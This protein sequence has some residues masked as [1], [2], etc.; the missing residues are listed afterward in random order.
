MSVDNGKWWVNP[1]GF[2]YGFYLFAGFVLV[3]VMSVLVLT[4][5]QLQVKIQDIKVH[6]Q[7][8]SI[9][10]L[11][12]TSAS[13][14][15]FKQ[16]NA[17]DEDSIAEA[18][19]LFEGKKVERTELLNTI[20]QSLTDYIGIDYDKGLRKKHSA[21]YLQPVIRAE[22]LHETYKEKQDPDSSVVAKIE[23]LLK[24]IRAVQG[25]YN[26]AR[27][28]RNYLILKRNGGYGFVANYTAVSNIIKKHYNLSS[29]PVEIV[30]AVLNVSS[31]I[32]EAEKNRYIP[33]FYSLMTLHSDLLILLLVLMMGALG[34]LIHLAQG[35]LYERDWKRFSYYIFRPL[36]GMSAAFA[37]YILVK[38][39]VLV[40]GNPASAGVTN[41]TSL[42][43]FFISF[44]AI[45]SGL[46]AQ[47][48]LKNI[49]TAGE[50]LFRTVLDDTTSR[51]AFGVEDAVE[52]VT[53][54][55]A[56]KRR[57]ELIKLLGGVDGQVTDWIAGYTP[58]PED[59]QR[60]IS[61]W[62]DKPL[63]ELFFD[64][65]VVERLQPD[66]KP[67]SNET[68]ENGEG[69]STDK[70]DKKEDKKDDKKSGK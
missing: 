8:V 24:Q 14:V 39:G 70:S 47:N 17:V 29:V 26:L 60:I 11:K 67:P 36:L 20:N 34:G 55:N 35:Y 46:M 44:L 12:A 1:H 43:P 54:E 32:R 49:H 61:A 50:N 5:Y 69:A 31:E 57:A 21:T 18:A 6:D 40:V 2:F 52:K 63:H 28:R 45:I 42:N 30:S 37:I 13:L 53:R 25:E 41:A 64:E 38:A 65:Q 16:D 15:L 59:K 27:D 9:P 51:W 22:Y 7:P 33:F 58:I 56:G 62:L 10:V 4:A 23:K 19:L 3:G 48:A 66:S 68:G